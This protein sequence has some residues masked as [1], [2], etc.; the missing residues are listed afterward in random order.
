MEQAVQ[1]VIDALN[2]LGEADLKLD[3][4]T[5]ILTVRDKEFAD[6]KGG[7][8]AW[9][10]HYYNKGFKNTED[11]VSPRHLPSSKFQLLGRVDRRD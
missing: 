4:T 11:S 7:K 10:Q 6:Y 2:K 9:K 8:K 1:K 5:S 3:E